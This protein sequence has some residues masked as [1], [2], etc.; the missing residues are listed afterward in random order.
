MSKLKFKGE[1]VKK[2]KRKHKEVTEDAVI[3]EGETE[4]EGWVN[5]PT[6]LHAHGPRS[7]FSLCV[8]ELF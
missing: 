5:T 4:F 8:S 2:K 3:A 1:P 6:A 7:C